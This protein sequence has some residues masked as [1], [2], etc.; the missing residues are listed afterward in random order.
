ML[1]REVHSEFY[2]GFADLLGRYKDR[3]KDLLLPSLFS[4]RFASFL[5]AYEQSERGIA[6]HVLHQNYASA[7][8]RPAALHQRSCKAAGLTPA[9][10]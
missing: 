8:V 3:G 4:T 10:L 2:R 6:C 7:R 9:L 1:S 5:R